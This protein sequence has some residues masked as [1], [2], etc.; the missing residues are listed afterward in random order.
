MAVGQAQVCADCG[1][2]LATRRA[3]CT[4][5]GAWP[6][7]DDG[8]RLPALLGGCAQASGGQRAGAVLLDLAGAG[9]VALL[10]LVV[11][12]IVVGP[13]PASIFVLWAGGVV[14][15]YALA[16]LLLVATTGRTPALAMQ[17]VRLVD[18]FSGTPLGVGRALRGAR[19]GILLD[20]RAG[21]DPVGTTSHVVLEPVA[22]VV[23]GGF[24]HAASSAPPSSAP[25]PAPPTSTAVPEPPQLPDP[26]PLPAA[27]GVRAQEGTVSPSVVIAL[28]DGQRFEIRGTTLVG[29]NPRPDALETV[30]YLVSVNDM[31]RSVS[32][33]HASFRWDGQVLWV[34]DRASTNGT[35][36]AHPDGQRV[37]VPAGAEHPAHPGGRVEL[38]ERIVQIE[39]PRDQGGAT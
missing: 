13:A 1:A 30:D 25:V 28:D 4:R 16:A 21:R 38:G 36:I 11:V 14:V 8:P 27:D 39:T 31:S 29:R 10:A 18:V 2:H 20:V 22:Q 32:K 37:T 12:R 33:T 23:T 19:S 24:G 17:G 9:A 7:A 3:P 35:V 15:I 5:C 34:T 6:A 26:P